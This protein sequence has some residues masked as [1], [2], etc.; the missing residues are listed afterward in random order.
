[1]HHLCNAIRH[2]AKDCP[3]IFSGQLGVERKYSV[4]SR[5]ILGMLLKEGHE[6]KYLTPSR[7]K[8]Q[9]SSWNIQGLD[10]S[11]QGTDELKGHL[12]LSQSG[13]GRLGCRGILRAAD[14]AQITSLLLNSSSSLLIITLSFVFALAPGLPHKV[15]HL[16]AIFKEV[17]L[18]RML[19]PSN[20]NH[21]AVPKVRAEGVSVDGGG[22]KN[23]PEVGVSVDHVSQHYEQEVA[24]DISLMDL[25]NDDMTDASEAPLQLAQ[26]NPNSAKQR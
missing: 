25:I 7:E 17:I 1:M 22:H 18:N 3:L 2:P 9:H 24:V 20:L 6:S 5:P 8:D 12:T 14:L 15:G 23:H 19:P 26:E 13:H 10:V 11:K 16:D 21:R 4:A